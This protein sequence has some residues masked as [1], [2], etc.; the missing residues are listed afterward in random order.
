M[1]D[2]ARRAQME[3]R[4]G[5]GQPVDTYGVPCPHVRAATQVKEPVEAPSKGINEAQVQIFWKQAIKEAVQDSNLKALAGA[6][7]DMGDLK[8]Y[9]E[10]GTPSLVL[11]GKT[12]EGENLRVT[13]PPNLI[14]AIMAKEGPIHVEITDPA[15]GQSYSFYR[16][17][18]DVKGP[19]IY[20]PKDMTNHFQVDQKVVAKIKPLSVWDF[21]NQLEGKASE[22]VRLNKD[23]VM[24]ADLGNKEI[25]IKSFEYNYHNGE[26]YV[27]FQVK[28]ITGKV[29]RF[30]VYDNGFEEPRFTIKKGNGFNTIQGIDYDHKRDS[31][32]IEYD[33][34]MDKNFFTSLRFMEPPGKIDLD[35]C[36]IPEEM[37]LEWEAAI[38][39]QK[40]IEMGKIGAKVGAKIAEE[41]YN[42]KISLNPE[43]Q[44]PDGE[45]TRD[46]ESGVLEVRSTADKSELGTHLGEAA[47][48]VR[49]RNKAG[50]AI[51]VYIDKDTGS[52][53]YKHEPVPKTQNASFIG[54]YP[55]GSSA[56]YQ[57][58]LGLVLSIHDGQAPNTQTTQGGQAKPS[59]VDHSKPRDQL[60]RSLNQ[61]TTPAQDRGQEQGSKTTNSDP[62]KAS[63]DDSG[64]T[65]KAQNERQQ[66]FVGR[67]AAART[68]DKAA[69]QQRHQRNHD[70]KN[71]APS[72]RESRADMKVES[73]D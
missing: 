8:S 26:T 58:P 31:L 33:F 15:T 38:N 35:T 54:F 68:A 6:A 24:V 55:M 7:R 23:G 48:E 56:P 36:R 59:Y 3:N 69:R 62:K 12:T 21:V 73:F 52:F 61:S 5:L 67:V 14:K 40:K 60:Q 29:E 2:G 53:E 30:R 17:L 25:P 50:I 37:R 41:E 47:D 71:R 65:L 43:T 72:R 28:D 20:I 51:S 66:T 10:N 46:S 64:N 34:H 1:G 63:V 39:S 18:H 45:F 9:Y 42:V 16:D 57:P 22:V 13:I 32:K 44:G 11:K 70:S 27:G 19:V 4:F 49:G